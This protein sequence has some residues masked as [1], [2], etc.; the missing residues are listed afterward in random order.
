MGQLTMELAY[1]AEQATKKSEF[2]R[3]ARYYVALAKA[4]PDRA[5]AFS[6]ACASFE[7][8]GMLKETRDACSAALA[9][10]GATTADSAS[11]I[12]GVLREPGKLDP[13]LI[14]DVDAVLAH[15]SAQIGKDQKG[16]RE[17]AVLSCRVGVRLEDVARLTTC[18]KTLREL[19]PKAPETLAFEAALA[20]K[21]SDWDAAK[22]V[23]ERSRQAGLPSAAIANMERSIEQRRA[24]QPA[25]PLAGLAR[26]WWIAA[27][28]LLA[29]GAALMVFRRRTPPTAT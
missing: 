15:L 5:T 28:A 9:R 24:S 17:V 22:Q 13:K 25:A 20:L 21:T 7:Q 26:S 1:R 8:A 29:V 6:K 27:L 23:V 14:E 2:A 4:V 19:A 18:T 3:A 11:F 16:Q 12:S 10:P